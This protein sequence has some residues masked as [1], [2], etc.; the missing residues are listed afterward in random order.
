MSLEE[1]VDG[2]GTRED[3]VRFVRA[4]LSDFR[5]HAETWENPT[6]DRYFEALAE[7]IEM[8]DSNYRNRGEA[9]PE[10]PTW[11]I[12]GKMLFAASMYE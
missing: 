12:M 9:L 1:Q 5:D 10:Q 8:M 6:L 3:L 7:W 11:R 4:L 2:I